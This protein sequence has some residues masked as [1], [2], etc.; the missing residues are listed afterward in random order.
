MSD[1]V[2]FVGMIVTPEMVLDDGTD[3]RPL[4]VQPFRVAAPDCAR[5]IDVA[6]LIAEAQAQVDEQ[7]RLLQQEVDAVE[8]DEAIRKAKSE[9]FS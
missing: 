2:R 6:R 7:E 4:Q 1:R 9:S 5:P 8:T 3:L